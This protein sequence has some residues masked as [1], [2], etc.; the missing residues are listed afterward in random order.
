MAVVLPAAWCCCTIEL[1]LP[2]EPKICLSSGSGSSIRLSGVSAHSTCLAGLWVSVLYLYHGP[3]T[4]QPH[5]CSLTSHASLRINNSPPISFGTWNSSLVHYAP[6]LASISRVSLSP[7][8]KL[9]GCSSHPPP[10]FALSCYVLLEAT[11]RLFR[12]GI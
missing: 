10:F 12:L 9:P 6:W 11:P 3:S 1:H 4:R 5:P 8:S 7:R 2:E